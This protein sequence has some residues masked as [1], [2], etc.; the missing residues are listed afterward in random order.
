MLAKYSAALTIGCLLVTGACLVGIYQ[1]MT[2]AA[3]AAAQASGHDSKT[4]AGAPTT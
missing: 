2:A 4:W 1:E 3:Q